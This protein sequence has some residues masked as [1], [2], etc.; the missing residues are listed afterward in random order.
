MYF[1]AGI[2]DCGSAWRSQCYSVLGSVHA[3]QTPQHRMH[4]GWRSCWSYTA[5]HG[6][7]DARAARWCR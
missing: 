2:T 6:M 3:A 1:V 5:T 7:G 4:M